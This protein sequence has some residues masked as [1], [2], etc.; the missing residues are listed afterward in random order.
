MVGGIGAWRPVPSNEFAVGQQYEVPAH[1]SS[2]AALEGADAPDHAG[3][4]RSQV[5]N[6]T[7]IFHES[8]VVTYS[9][10]AASQQLSGV[11]IGGQ[12]DPVTSELDFQTGVKL[13]LIARN[14]NWT[15][16]NQAYQKPGNATTPRRTRG[17]LEAITTNVE[18]NGAVARPLTLALFDDAMVGLVN[19]GGIADGENV[20]AI[21]NTAQLRKL[22]ELFRADKIAVDDERFIGGVRVRTVYTTFGVLNFALDQDMPQDQIALVNFDVMQLVATEVPGKGVLFREELAKTG[23]NEKF[24]MYGELGL[25]HGPEWM[26]A[27]ITD[28]ATA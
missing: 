15:I 22:N 8:V 9:K 2:R 12:S 14:L 13:E 20:V 23:S 5:T 11:G 18:A 1:N 21:A 24:Q 16:L 26:H 7:Q 6:V 19:S 17:L 27:K 25:D 4:V 3:V 28:L 10:Q